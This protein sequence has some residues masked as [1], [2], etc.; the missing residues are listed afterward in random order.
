MDN[1]TIV[2]T[3]IGAKINIGTSNNDVWYHVEKKSSETSSAS[4]I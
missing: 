3:V 4:F 1:M 2:L